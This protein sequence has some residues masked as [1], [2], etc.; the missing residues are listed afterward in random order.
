MWPPCARAAAP[1]TCRATCWALA[2][3][4]RNPREQAAAPWAFSQRALVAGTLGLCDA[5]PSGVSPSH[6]KSPRCGFRR[7]WG[8]EI[9]ILT[10]ASEARHLQLRSQGGGFGAPS[11]GP[12]EAPSC[13]HIG[14]APLPGGAG[15]AGSAGRLRGLRG[16]AGPRWVGK[17]AFLNLRFSGKG[18][19]DAG[20]QTGVGVRRG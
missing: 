1:L 8:P 14:L 11:P 20:T 5:V 17:E 3:L 7:P 13:P 18:G 9:C 6:R 4:M 19:S 12:E 2:P 16:G 15:A 10:S